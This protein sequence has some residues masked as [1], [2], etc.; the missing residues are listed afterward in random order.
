MN[1]DRAVVLLDLLFAQGQVSHKGHVEVALNHPGVRMSG[2]GAHAKEDTWKD[3]LADR[4]G[5][6]G[7]SQRGGR[8]T[9]AGTALTAE[10]V[11]GRLIVKRGSARGKGM[12]P[13]LGSERKG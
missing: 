1:H 7:S 9:V 5:R 6:S 2:I 13:G 4:G 10:Q 12:D 11:A 8:P 3:A